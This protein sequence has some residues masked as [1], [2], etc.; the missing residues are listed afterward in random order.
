MKAATTGEDVTTVGALR[1][2]IAENSA[3]AKNH[4]DLG[5]AKLLLGNLASPETTDSPYSGCHRVCHEACC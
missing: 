5:Y 3:K 1:Q 2:S 4:P